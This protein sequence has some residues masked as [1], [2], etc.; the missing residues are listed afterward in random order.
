M[1]SSSSAASS[2]ACTA[3][4][5]TSRLS[6]MSG[7]TALTS[8][9]AEV[10]GLAAMDTLSKRP[11]RSSSVCAVSTSQAAMLAKPS[12]STS[13]NETMPVSSYERVLPARGDLHGVADRVVL[14][15]GGAGV[16]DDLPR[17][18]GPFAGLELERGEARV[19]GVVADARALLGDRLAVV[20]DDVGGVG[21]LGRDVAAG[22]LDLGQ[23]PDL[24]EDGFRDGHAAAAEGVLDDLLAADRRRRSSRTMRRRAR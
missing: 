7:C 8:S 4:S 20:A 10:P 2:L 9:A 18:L 21:L 5:L 17:A 6:G 15:G 23:R 3:L 14:L 11:S 13:P 16:D 24:C 19:G 12:E 1:P 22:G